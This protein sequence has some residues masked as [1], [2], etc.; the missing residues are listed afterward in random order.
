MD[1]LLVG[2]GE[3]NQEADDGQGD[4]EGP[5][6]EGGA[7]CNQHQEDFFGGVSNGGKGVRRKHSQRFY[8]A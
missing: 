3:D 7:G 2:D 4:G 1:G 6:Q 5:A 8:F